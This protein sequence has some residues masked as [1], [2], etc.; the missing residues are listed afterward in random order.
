MKAA[1]GS[2]GHELVQAP[3]VVS[4]ELS[5]ILACAS[6]AM[7]NNIF[8]FRMLVLLRAR[9]WRG[10]RDLQFFQELAEFDRRVTGAGAP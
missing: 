10:Q 4:K 6:M 5:L 3:P 7:V 1:P 9:D 2:A 8:A